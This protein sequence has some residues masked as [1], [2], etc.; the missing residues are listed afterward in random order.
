MARQLTLDLQGL[1]GGKHWFS[2]SLQDAGNQPAFGIR[3]LVAAVCGRGLVTRPLPPQRSVSLSLSGFAFN[4]F[5]QLPADVD[6]RWCKGNENRIGN[7]TI[8][9]VS[10]D[11]PAPR[12]IKGHP[13]LPAKVPGL[14]TIFVI[15][16]QP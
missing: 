8:H 7:K 4:V 16:N 3:S 15:A 10:I 6:S 14:E 11:R 12:L 13:Q 2:V 5:G 9:R 1:F